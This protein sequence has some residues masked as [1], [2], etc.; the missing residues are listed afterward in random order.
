MKYDNEKI[1]A[2][3]KKF[4]IWEYASMLGMTPIKKGNNYYT[5]KEHDSVRIDVQRNCFWRNSTGAKGTIIDFAIEFENKDIKEV[6]SDLANIVKGADYTTQRPVQ[7]SFTDQKK[8]KAVFTLPERDNNVKNVYAYLVNTRKI[9]RE[10]VSNLIQSKNLY[11]DKHKNCVFVSYDQNGKADFGSVRGT[12]TEK[13]FLADI[14]GSNYDRC[15]YLDNKSNSIIVTESVIDALSIMTLQKNKTDIT[16]YNY[17][18]MNS[19][20]KYHSLIEHLNNNKNIDTVFLAL[21]NDNAGILAVNKITEELQSL[22]YVGKIKPFL[23]R[24]QKDWN[25]ELK[26]IKENNFSP[27]YFSATQAQKKELENV[28]S[29]IV[30]KKRNG[31]AIETSEITQYRKHLSDLKIPTPIT[32]MIF[33]ASEISDNWQF[34]NHAVVESVIKQFNQVKKNNITQNKNFENDIERG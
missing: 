12:N 4:P 25:A 16:S 22:G 2:E 23:P 33:T 9:D 27:N 31:S 29:S 6:L 32:E 3:I 14:E 24:T 13:R 17:L 1:I 21:D 15:F 18:S 7:I 11:Q 8:E 30:D 28:Y 26:Y 34:Y 19:T 5:L 20:Q 10:I